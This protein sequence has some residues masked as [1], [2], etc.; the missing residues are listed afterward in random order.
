MHWLPMQYACRHSYL[1]M[2]H[3]IVHVLTTDAVCLQSFIN[4]NVTYN[5]IFIDCWCSMPAV[6]HTYE[7]Y[8]QCYIYWLRMQHACCHSHIWMLHTMLYLLTADA[9]C[10]LSL[11]QLNIT[12]NA[13]FIDC[14]CSITAVIHTYKCYIQCYMYWLPMLYA[15]LLSFIHINVIYNATFIECWCSMPAVIHTCECFMQFCMYWLPMQYADYHSY[16]WMLNTMLHLLT[17]DAACLLS[18]IHMNV[19][20]NAIFIDC[21]CNMPADI[22][23]YERY[24]QCYIYWL[25]MQHAFCHSCNWMLHIMLYFFNVDAACLL[26]FIH[27]NVTYNATFIDCRCSMP[28]VIHTYECFKQFCIY[29]LRM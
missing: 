24:I 19:T 7:H 22:H 18:F 6:I 1:W 11:I 2:F 26:S 28:A 13:I 27:M 5:A 16:I 12:Y 10:L 17:A 4:M 25:L 8:I 15:C 3:A 29:W 21:W 9:A 20:Y 23:T 14:W